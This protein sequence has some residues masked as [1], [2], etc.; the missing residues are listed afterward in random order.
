MQDPD[1]STVFEVRQSPVKPA[2][3][4]AIFAAMTLGTA[5]PLS[6][7]LRAP[8]F[9]AADAFMLVMLA[10]FAGLTWLGL[11][12]ALQ[13]RRVAVVLSPEGFC[14]LRASKTVIPW[15]EIIAISSWSGRYA[16]LRLSLTP[17]M[18]E[19][20]LGKP[21]I[22]RSLKWLNW[23]STSPIL[24]VSTVHLS[25]SVTRLEQIAREYAAAHGGLQDD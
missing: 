19:E 21:G 5:V 1:P 22:W 11:S 23:A 18:T 10:V 9:D 17:R 7:L 25:I 14:D 12:K 15:R 20:M 3:A 8:G 16:H 6:W 4:G 2:V 13:G 24:P